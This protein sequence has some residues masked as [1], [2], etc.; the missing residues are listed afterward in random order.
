MENPFR[1]VRTNV[2]MG[3]VDLGVREPFSF[4]SLTEVI[5]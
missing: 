4:F 2:L 3:I 1:F 5:I